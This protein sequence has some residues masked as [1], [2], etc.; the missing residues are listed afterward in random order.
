MSHVV[1][2][3]TTIGHKRAATQ[4]S[5]VFLGGKGPEKHI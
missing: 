3:G 2:A 4:L 1:F 5:K